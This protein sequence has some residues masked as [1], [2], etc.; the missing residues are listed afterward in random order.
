[1]NIKT[2]ITLLLLST[3]IGVIADETPYISP[4]ATYFTSDGE[5]EN[6]AMSGSAPL[7]AVFRANPENVGS[8]RATY[9]WRFYLNSMEDA[10]YLT[11]Y[12]QDTEYTFTQAGGH[13]IVCY[14]TFIDGNDT[15][16]YTK[17]YWETEGQPLTCTVSQSQLEMPN[18]F[19]PNGDGINDIYRAKEWQSLVEFHATILN[20]WGQRLYEW[21][22][23]ASGWDGTYHG[24]DVKQGVYFVV[25]KAKGADGIHYN[26]RKD[27]N[28]LRGYTDKTG[29]N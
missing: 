5:E 19:S 4:T 10:P 21:T 3:A 28:L 13:Y 23:P 26:I 27:I 15:V 24:H 20:R 7:R 22:D 12:E 1:M 9:E 11:R 8:Y 14:A 2:I 25:V 29:P 17:E 6:P 18:A 16:A